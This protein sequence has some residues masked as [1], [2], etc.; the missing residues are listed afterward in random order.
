MVHLVGKY[1]LRNAYHSGVFDIDDAAIDEALRSIAERRADPV[2][3]GRYKKAV[4]SSPQREVVLRSLA[5]I[6]DEDG[7][8]WT[9]NAYKIALDD[10]VDNPSQYVG[11]LVIH[12]Y[13]A[14]LE[15]VRERYYRFRDSLFAAYVL[16][17][18][19][20]FTP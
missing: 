5:R 2:L 19:R 16:A 3:E 20:Q 12:E 11:Q 7:E 14:E 9:T 6:R 1:A 18:P 17:R 15:K 4:G 8:C 10:G 13:G